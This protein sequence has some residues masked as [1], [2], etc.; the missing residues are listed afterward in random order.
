MHDIKQP[1]KQMA[2]RADLQKTKF[3]TEM[4]CLQM[5]NVA[6][7]TERRRN[8]ATVRIVQRHVVC[9]VLLIAQQVIAR[10]LRTIDPRPHLE[11]AFLAMAVQVDQAVRGAVRL[12]SDE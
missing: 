4:S 7:E 10:Q 8:A 1:E 12:G 11:T 6:L 3:T 5:L 9:S 2:L